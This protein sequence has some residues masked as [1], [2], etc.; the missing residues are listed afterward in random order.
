MLFSSEVMKQYAYIFY[1]L[2]SLIIFISLAKEKKMVVFFS[3]AIITLVY[4][5]LSFSIGSFAFSKGY[6]LNAPDYKNFL[7]WKYVE[8]STFFVLFSSTCIFLIDSIFRPYYISATQ[9]INNINRNKVKYFTCI[10]LLVA[11]LFIFIPLDMSFMGSSGDMSMVPKTIAAISVFYL[12]NTKKY[13][14]RFIVYF[15]V[16]GLFSIFSFENKR[17]AIF[18]IFPIL[19]LEAIFYSKEFNLKIVIHITLIIGIIAF[20]IIIMSITR[21]YGGFGEISS[22]FSAIPFVLE[23]INTDLFW[24]YFFNNIEVNYTFYNSM[25]ALEYIQ[26]DWSLVSYGSTIIKAVFIFIPRTIFEAKPQSIIDLYTIYHNPVF[27]NVGGSSPINIF[28]EFFWNFGFYA[29]IPLSFLYMILSH[30]F[31]NMINIMKKNRTAIAILLLYAYMDFLVY[32]R[33]SGLDMYLVN[34]LIGLAFVVISS[35]IIQ[36]LQ[37]NGNIHDYSAQ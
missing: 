10:S 37:A 8:W 16:I 26:S 4:I 1:L 7:G 18:L 3:P 13:H 23:Y 36:L 20:L 31:L 29:V 11:T 28:S 9:S 15:L 32:V 25:Q 5:L 27:R 17:E 33:G 34:V 2:F 24:S 6:V 35:F 21:G 19:F 22:V 30:I 14:S 12:V